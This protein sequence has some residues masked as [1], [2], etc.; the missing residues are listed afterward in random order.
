MR[1][2]YGAVCSCSDVLHARR[3]PRVGVLLERVRLLAYNGRK[4]RSQRRYRHEMC[5]LGK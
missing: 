1:K 3:S 5:W 4:R 2:I